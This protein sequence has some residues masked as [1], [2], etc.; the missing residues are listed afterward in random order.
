ML[1]GQI[2]FW[3]VDFGASD[4]DRGTAQELMFLTLT[5][6]LVSSWSQREWSPRAISI[7]SSVVTGLIK[8]SVAPRLSACWIISG[9]STEDKTTMGRH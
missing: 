3:F 7:R 8:K 6:G 4:V 1:H 9:S 2:R 5:L